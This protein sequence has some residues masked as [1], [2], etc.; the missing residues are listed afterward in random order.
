[1]SQNNNDTKKYKKA[2]FNHTKGNYQIMEQVIKQSI[3][4]GFNEWQLQEDQTIKELAEYLLFFGPFSE[5]IFY[6]D[7]AARFFQ[8]QEQTDYLKHLQEMVVYKNPFGYL[9]TF[10]IP[11]DQ[12]KKIPFDYVKYPPFKDDLSMHIPVSDYG[13]MDRVILKTKQAGYN[14]IQEEPGDTVEHLT[15][16]LL[17]LRRFPF[18]IFTHEFAQAFFQCKEEEDNIKHLQEMVIYKNPFEYLKDFT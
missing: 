1:M 10:I 5:E 3:E 16:W 14:W 4:A 13:I 7:F 8:R 2:L 12:L 15:Y 17:R 9:K 11:A 6:H 18:N